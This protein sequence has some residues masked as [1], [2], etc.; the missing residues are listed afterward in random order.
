MSCKET[1]C[2][3]K[4]PEDGRKIQN[5]SHKKMWHIFPCRGV[6]CVWSQAGRSL[7]PSTPSS[8]PLQELIWSLNS[9][10]HSLFIPSLSIDAILLPERQEGSDTYYKVDENVI[11]KV[12]FYLVLFGGWWFLFFGFVCF[13]VCV[14]GSNRSLWGKNVIN[15]SILVWELEKW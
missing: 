3:H 14:L 11:F 8:L 1:A 6:R 7:A 5:Q 15:L 4:T 12:G 9:L 2:P 10:A 13:K